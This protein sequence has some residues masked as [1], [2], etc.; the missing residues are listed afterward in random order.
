MRSGGATG[1]VE[2][3]DKRKAVVLIGMMRME[4]HVR[5]LQHAKAPLDVQSSRS[6]KTDTVNRTAKFE[7]KIDIRGMRMDESLAVLKTLSTGPLSLM[8][9]VCVSFTEKEMAY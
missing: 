9:V 8:P 5:D 1:Q 7:N 6:V 3:I 4:V 2:S